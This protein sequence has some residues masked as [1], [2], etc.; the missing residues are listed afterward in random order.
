[1]TI[2]SIPSTSS[3][4]ASRPP[5][6]PS[7]GVRHRTRPQETAGKHSSAPDPGIR[8]HLPAFSGDDVRPGAVEVYHR[9]SASPMVVLYPP[10]TTSL[11]LSVAARYP[12][13]WLMVGP[14]CRPEPNQPQVPTSQLAQLGPSPSA[15]DEQVGTT[16]AK[17]LGHG[18]QVGTTRAKPLR[19]GQTGRHNSGQATPPWT[20]RSA[21]LGQATRHGRTGR[22]NWG[23]APRPWTNR[24]AQLG[25]SS[26]AMDKQVG[27]TGAKPLGRGQTGRHNWGQ[28]LGM[29]EQVAQLG[30]AT[31]PWTNRSAQLGP[32]ISAMEVRDVPNRAEV[33]ECD[34]TTWPERCRCP[35][36]LARTP[37]GASQR[38]PLRVSKTPTSGISLS[39]G[40]PSHRLRSL[41]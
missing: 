35:V 16:R 20:N 18:Q 7:K 17:P 14:A 24:S 30:Q 1:V 33:L 32:S 29:D 8:Y 4:S 37:V 11:T 39:S 40:R 25:P 6:T 36:A 28:A 38:P 22:H 19:R 13:L 10:T 26:S 41:V 5:T 31:R 12:S 2:G 9:Q 23:Q 15:M 3:G 34:G 21:Q 27:T